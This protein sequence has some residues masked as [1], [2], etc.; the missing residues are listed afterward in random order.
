MTG[1]GQGP[2]DDEVG[3]EDGELEE[4]EQTVVHRV[5]NSNRIQP[6]DVMREGLEVMAE[7]MR[8]QPDE[9]LEELKVSSTSSLHSYV[10]LLLLWWQENG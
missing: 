4:G 6:R 8:D 3:E 7:R 2:E 10:C 1:G 9:L 5:N